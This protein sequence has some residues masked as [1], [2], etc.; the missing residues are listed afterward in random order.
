MARYPIAATGTL[1]LTYIGISDLLKAKKELQEVEEAFYKERAE[2]VNNYPMKKKDITATQIEAIYDSKLGTEPWKYDSRFT[3]SGSTLKNVP[4]PPGPPGAPPGMPAVRRGNTPDVY[5]VANYPNTPG[6]T[7]SSG[8]PA[9]SEPDYMTYTYS[10]GRGGT[11]ATEAGIRDVN[12]PW[13]FNKA[14]GASWIDLSVS[15]GGYN[16]GFSAK[17]SEN[18]HT[19]HDPSAVQAHQFF[20]AVGVVPF[21]Y[22]AAGGLTEYEAHMLKLVGDA[23]NAACKV[24]FEAYKTA[25]DAYM[26]AYGSKAAD[27]TFVSSSLSGVWAGYKQD[28]GALLFNRPGTLNKKLVQELRGKN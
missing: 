24:K 12:G 27:F 14:R 9:I 4:Y 6:T 2:L 13:L 26:T 28:S 20:A 3:A 8:Y 15:E 22:T 19:N 17:G 23:W 21:A 10:S 16:A 1:D 7:P 25:Y 18:T 5:W 11:T